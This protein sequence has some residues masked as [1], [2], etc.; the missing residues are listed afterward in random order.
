MGPSSPGFSRIFPAA[1]SF[2]P[3]QFF[4][5]SEIPFFLKEFRAE[6]PILEVIG[7]FKTSKKSH[8]TKLK[9]RRNTF[10]IDIYI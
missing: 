9:S 8:K 5:S 6:P 10:N 7:L 4:L 1:A 3:S 2:L